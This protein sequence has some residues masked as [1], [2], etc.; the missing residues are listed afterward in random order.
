MEFIN[1]QSNHL[2]AIKAAAIFIYSLLVVSTVLV[3]AL[4]KLNPQREGFHKVFVIIRSWW[5]IATFFILA[6]SWHRWGLLVGMGLISLLS[7]NEYFKVSTVQHKKHFKVLLSMMVVLQYIA[8]ATQELYIF[9]ALM[10]VLCL[11][12]VP[13][14]VIFKATIKDITATTG[15]G[16]GATLVLYYMSHIPA[17]T[18]FSEL[19][20]SPY[21]A[22]MAIFVLLMVTW[23]NDIFQFLNGKTFGGKK[24]V[25]EVSPNKT[26]GGFI[27]G[28]LCTGIFGAWLCTRWLDMD[29]TSALSL[30]I[31]MSVT[32][33]LGDLFFSSIKR[34]IGVKDFSNVL[35]GHGGYLDRLDSLIFTSPLFFHYLLFFERFS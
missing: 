2:E 28:F 15:A 3:L 20:L 25:P 26:V 27:G 7:I 34:F 30:G 31:L 23:T 11:W 12:I 19:N 22:T 14:I 21:K 29:T 13:S 35:P 5:L 9:L 1:V 16:F 18:N 33:M 10:P 24:L 8:I 6:L 4:K 32:G 17:L